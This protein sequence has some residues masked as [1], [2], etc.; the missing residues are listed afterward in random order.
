MKIKNIIKACKDRTR[1]V[2]V[3]ADGAGRWL[4]DG[5]SLWLMP[6]YMSLEEE[7][8]YSMYDFSDSLRG[9]MIYEEIGA[10]TVPVDIYDDTEKGDVEI[11]DIVLMLRGEAYRPIKSEGGI[12]YIKEDYFSIFN[13]ESWSIYAKRTQEGKPYV[14]I[15]KGLIQI[16]M[17]M[18]CA[19]ETAELLD[20][21]SVIKADL[22]GKVGGT[23]K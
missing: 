2:A 19:V 7:A 4:G 15:Y 21:V 20:M 6:E 16:G 3:Y 8:I 11:M 23:E 14:C 13:D 5:A 12:I 17:I 18:P 22:E 9:K 1:I 10:E